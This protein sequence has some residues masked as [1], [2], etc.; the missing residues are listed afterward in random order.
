MTRAP[1]GDATTY[2]VVN[3]VL[4]A[5]MLEWQAASLPGRIEHIPE[6][7]DR[8]HFHWLVRLRGEEKDYI[9]IWFS[10]RQRTVHVE[11]QVMPAPEENAED[12]YRFLLK[13]NAE[14]REVHLA[15]G[16]EEGIYL[17]TQIPFGELTRE[18]LDET[19]GA[20]VAYTEEI[21]PTGMSIGLASLY[22]RKKRP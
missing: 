7:D 6:P 19:I 15:I 1:I 10:L 18:R 3:D 21:F 8:G 22:R 17:V 16:P 4:A 20:V 5:W 9:T 12:L 11:T 14:L 13:K 2:Q